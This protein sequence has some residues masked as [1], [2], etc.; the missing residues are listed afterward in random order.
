[1]KKFNFITSVFFAILLTA[2][3]NS[4]SANIQEEKLTLKQ[5]CEQ[6]GRKDSVQCNI[7]NDTKVPEAEKEY[8]MGLLYF[9]GATDGSV[10][11]NCDKAEYWS[12]KSANKGM[13]KA[14]NMLGMI[15][16]GDCR[17]SIK[18]DDNIS[19]IQTS[20]MD[21]KK[22]EQY[23]LQAIKLNAKFAKNNLAHL[24]REGG[25]GLQ[26][27]YD[28][29]IKFYKEAIADDPSRAYDGLSQVYIQQKKYKEALPYL[30]KGAEIGNSQAQNNLGYAYENGFGD[31]EVDIEKAKYWY[32]KS[33]KQG[34]V[35]AENNL[36]KLSK[37]MDKQK[38]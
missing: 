10:P 23:Y 34:N 30:K 11:T 35:L 3:S 28:K 4:Q 27:D 7:L 18:V 13:G 1:M 24:Y 22:A 37:E 15:Y 14:F 38:K 2:C 29:A 33:A 25:Y 5:E 19:E 6:S 32:E 16:S 21:Y 31:L 12:E 36:K 17:T 8:A 20:I 9:W 26:Q